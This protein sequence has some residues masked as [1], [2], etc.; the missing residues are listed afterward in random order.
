MLV[1]LIQKV[2]FLNR[3]LEFS[4]ANEDFLLLHQDES[5]MFLRFQVRLL[6]IRFVNKSF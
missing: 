2:D 5:K 1:P 3:S 4:Y 6:L